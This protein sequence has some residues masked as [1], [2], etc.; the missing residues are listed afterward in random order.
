MPG[1]LQTWLVVIHG[2]TK[3]A[4]SS[5]SFSWLS[6]GCQCSRQVSPPCTLRHSM[7]AHVVW[8]VTP[9]CEETCKAWSKEQ[10]ACASDAFSWQEEGQ[11][12]AAICV[13]SQGGICRSCDCR[14]SFAM[15]SSLPRTKHRVRTS[16]FWRQKNR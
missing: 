13:A 15:A 2:G 7:V 14:T 1:K 9:S 3:P 11:H 10:D 4:Q 8:V 16:R 6:L 5:H 12:G